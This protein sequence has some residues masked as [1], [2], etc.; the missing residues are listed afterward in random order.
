[1]FRRQKKLNSII[2][3]NFTLNQFYIETGDNL[4]NPWT[5]KIQ[6]KTFKTI[7]SKQFETFLM[8]TQN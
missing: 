6:S 4:N 8:S 3:S 5:H 1:M 2:K 7:N